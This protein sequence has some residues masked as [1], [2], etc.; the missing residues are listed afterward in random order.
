MSILGLGGDVPDWSVFWTA[1][2]AIGSTVGSFVTAIAII[3][4]LW[5]TKYP[6]K[7]R[8][9]LAFSDCTT[10]AIETSMDFPKLV[11]LDISNVGNR[12]IYIQEWG[13][14]LRKKNRVQI[15]SQ[16][17]AEKFPA[18]IRKKL[19]PALPIYIPVEQT[20]ALYFE[21]KL[22]LNSVLE[23]V[24]EKTLHKSQKIKIYVIDS[25]GKQYV[26]KTKKTVAQLLEMSERK[27][28]K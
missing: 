2:G 18:L 3:V 12:D 4:A 11:S 25:S 28:E 8:L 24:D 6:Y 7:K 1:I 5:Q 13:Y 27:S 14:I 19:F 23:C 10:I 21:Q 15:L 9:K 16:V 22:F 20:E 26:V 17:S